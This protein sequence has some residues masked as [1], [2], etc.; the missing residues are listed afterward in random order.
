MSKQKMTKDIIPEDFTLFLAFVD[1]IPVIFFGLSMIKIGML[2][3]SF[4]FLAGAILCFVGGAGKV[5]W[6]IIVVLYKKNI[7][8]IFVQLRILLTAGFILM[9]LSLFIDYQKIN[10]NSIIQKIVSFPSCIFFLLG[11]AGMILMF[12]FAKKLDSSDVKANW[13]EQLTNGIS[14]ICIFIG[15]VL[16]K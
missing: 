3:N 2:F 10:L 8:F 11:L 6:K 14:Q 9:L 15:I 1:A 13:I 7:W 4:L 16:M 12:I 5:L